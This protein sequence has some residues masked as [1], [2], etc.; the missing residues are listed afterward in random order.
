[1][2]DLNNIRSFQSANTQQKNV[3]ILNPFF[4]PMTSGV[5]LNGGEIVFIP[6]Y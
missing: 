3:T 5:I 4:P 1:M 2:V 6:E